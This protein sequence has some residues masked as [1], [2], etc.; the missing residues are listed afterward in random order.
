[1]DARRVARD[2]G[3]P[4]RN[5][6]LAQRTPKCEAR[7]GAEAGCAFF[8]CR[9]QPLVVMI[10]AQAKKSNSLRSEA[11]AKA[12]DLAFNCFCFSQDLAVSGHPLIIGEELKKPS[13][14]RHLFRRK[15][16][17]P[18]R[19]QKLQRPSPPTRDTS[20]RFLRNLHMQPGLLTQ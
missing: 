9:G 13:R 11:G 19:I 5:T 3:C 8:W 1:M 10:F 7:R 12:F 15:K 18:V 20:Q 17:I 14:G 2:I 4:V 6:P 16:L